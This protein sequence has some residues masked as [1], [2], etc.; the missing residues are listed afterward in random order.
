MVLHFLL[1]ISN[2]LLLVCRNTMFLH[3]DFFFVTCKLTELTL[4][5]GDFF[6]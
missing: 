5:L 3:V 4:V 2:D 6:W 1:S